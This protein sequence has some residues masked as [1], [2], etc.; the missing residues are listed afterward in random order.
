MRL[1][2][3]LKIWIFQI[4][5][6]S[7]LSETEYFI[8]K[9]KNY[10]VENFSTPTVVFPLLMMMNNRLFKNKKKQKSSHLQTAFYI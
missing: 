9:K 4:V 6:I 5:L 10:A 2:I 3:N 8:R 1:N 7:L